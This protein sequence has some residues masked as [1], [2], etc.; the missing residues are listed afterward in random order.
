LLEVL[1]ADYTF[2]T[3]RLAKF[4][5]IEDKV[6]VHGNDFRMVKWLDN[7]RAGIT[8]MGSVLAMT[9]H[10]EQT[11]PVIRGAW[12]LETILGTPVPPPPPDVP[13]LDPDKK[14]K[15]LTVRQK[16]EQHRASPACAACHKLMD[17]MGFALENF[18]WMGRW[19]EKEKNGQALDVTGELPSGEKFSGPIEL[20]N[21]LL[22][23]KDDFLRHLTGKMLGF[24]LGRALQDG[25]S[26][27]IQHLVDDLAKDNY[28]ARTLIREI[29]L[30]V[31]FRNT[32]GGLAKIESIQTAIPKRQRPMVTK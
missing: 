17:P 27:T 13:A 24:A 18:D 9:S 6:D 25:D 12:I 30:S 21:A 10:Y 11:S 3:E 19:R 14:L 28:R 5:Q 26:C 23:R 7:R 29:V 4:Y 15:N 20:R 32:Q 8:G 22:N 31:P 16:L 1:T 2:L